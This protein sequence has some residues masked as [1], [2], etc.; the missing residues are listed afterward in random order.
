MFEHS[1]RIET[2]TLQM[3]VMTTNDNIKY[4]LPCLAEDLVIGITLSQLRKL[5]GFADDQK[6]WVALPGEQ[7][8]ELQ[9]V[10]GLL[11]ICRVVRHM[12]ML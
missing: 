4:H 5:A 3:T 8:G 7:A 11:S 9:E 6:V 1:F 12:A 10:D 2:P